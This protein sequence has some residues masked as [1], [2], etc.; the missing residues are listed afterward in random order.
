MSL[1]FTL[2]D[3]SNRY[4][5]NGKFATANTAGGTYGFVS[6]TASVNL[7]VN[8]ASGASVYRESYRVFAYQPGKSLQILNS[9]VMNPAKANLRQRIGYFTAN[10]GFFVDLAAND[11]KQLSNTLMLELWNNWAGICIEPVS[12]HWVGLLSNRKCKIFIKEE[13]SIVRKYRSFVC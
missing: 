10:N 4:Q 6:N 11:W 12:A 2:F 9:F 13:K 3:A 1:P 5:D 8:T 7:T